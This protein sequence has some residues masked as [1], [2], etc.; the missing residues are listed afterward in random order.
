MDF[1]QIETISNNEPYSYNRSMNEIDSIRETLREFESPAASDPYTNEV[2]RERL[3][4]DIR[5]HIGDV[6]KAVDDDVFTPLEMLS[7]SSVTPDYVSL[8]G[9]G[10]I[11]RALGDWVER[12]KD[13][14]NTTEVRLYKE[15]AQRMLSELGL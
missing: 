2:M 15:E 3:I 9:N 6:V 12:N 7:L 11:I 4:K 8:S 5:R 1:I 13:K 10:E 14:E